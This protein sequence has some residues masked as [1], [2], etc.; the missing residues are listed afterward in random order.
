MY[1]LGE[2]HAN[3]ILMVNLGQRALFSSPALPDAIEGV[4]ESVG[5]MIYS[6]YITGE[7]PNAPRGLRVVEVRVRLETNAQARRLTN[8][9]GQ[10]RIYLA[11]PVSP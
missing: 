8:L 4:V 11:D 3:E 2:I 1:A 9:E 6:N 10:L 7:D 5:A